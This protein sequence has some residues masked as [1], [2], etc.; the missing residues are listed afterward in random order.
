[1]DFQ[2]AAHSVV[3]GHILT[4]WVHP[5]LTHALCALLVIFHHLLLLLN[6]HPARLEPILSHQEALHAQTALLESF[7]ILQQ[8]PTF[9]HACSVQQVHMPHREAHHASHAQQDPTP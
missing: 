1:M 3:Q 7:Q 2:P 8:C 9:Q 6:V 5:H 4:S